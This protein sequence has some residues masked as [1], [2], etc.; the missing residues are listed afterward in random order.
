MESAS[1]LKHIKEHIFVNGWLA[2]EYQLKH[3][4]LE[5]D[6]DWDDYPNIVHFLTTTYE[7]F[8]SCTVKYEKL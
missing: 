6:L 8:K 5:A 7:D 3:F 1:P 2:V 4:D